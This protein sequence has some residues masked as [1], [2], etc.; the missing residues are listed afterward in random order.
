MAVSLSNLGGIACDQGDYAAA[1]SLQVEA[2]ATAREIGD[3]RMT[4]YCLEGL[5]A[6]ALGQEQSDRAARLFGAAAALREEI[7][8]PLTPVEAAGEENQ[9]SRLRQALGEEAFTAAWQAGEAMALEE[10]VEYAFRSGECSG[11]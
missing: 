7:G 8:C 10:A 4:A 6:V 9:V 11:K 2:L 5:A 1:R 3:R